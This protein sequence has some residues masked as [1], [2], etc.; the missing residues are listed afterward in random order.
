MA[1]VAAHLALLISPWLS[2]VMLRR[3]IVLVALTLSV[4]VAMQHEVTSNDDHN[5]RDD[6]NITISNSW[7]RG[8]VY[9]C[10]S[11]EASERCQRAGR[12]CCADPGGEGNSVCAPKGK[13]CIH[14]AAA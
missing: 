1:P 13:Q 2:D 10:T 7:L 5:L 6:A 14:I 3:G 8:A 4:V 11:T 12:E 9:D